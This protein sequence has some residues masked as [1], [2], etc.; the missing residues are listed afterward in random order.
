MRPLSLILLLFLAASALKAETIRDR[1]KNDPHFQLY[2]VVFGVLQ[3]S[4]GSIKEIHVANIVDAASDSKETV[5]IQLPKTYIEKAALAIRHHNYSLQQKDGK[6]VEFFTY[7]FYSPQ[8]GD[9]LI[10]DADA[11]VGG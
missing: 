6:P 7:Y 9:R 8:F 3:N 11:E 10:N 1:L 2:A 4:D 5:P